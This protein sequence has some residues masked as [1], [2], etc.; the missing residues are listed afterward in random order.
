M[1]PG[2]RGDLG[3]AVQDGVVERHNPG[4][5]VN[6]SIDERESLNVRAQTHSGRRRHRHYQYCILLMNPRKAGAVPCPKREPCDSCSLFGHNRL[7]GTPAL[8]ARSV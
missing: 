5:H 8:H 6:V 4:I 3:G 1:R 2:D 7:C